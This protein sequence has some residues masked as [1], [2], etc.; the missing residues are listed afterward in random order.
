MP[1]FTKDQSRTHS[2]QQG[3]TGITHAPRLRV[4][5]QNPMSASPMA[6]WPSVLSLYRT[7]DLRLV[8][9]IDILAVYLSIQAVVTTLDFLDVSA[10]SA[11]STPMTE[12]FV[13]S[14]ASSLGL[15]F[16]LRHS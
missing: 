3:D 8:F 12:L 11:R 5:R 7:A 16:W 15:L 1:I 9:W 4:S 13:L 14:I 2:A 10:Q 6:K